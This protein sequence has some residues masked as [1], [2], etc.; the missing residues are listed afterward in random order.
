M[1]IVS[2]GDHSHEMSSCFLRK[3]KKKKSIT[4]LLS[5]VVMISILRIQIFKIQ[6]K[7][8]ALFSGQKICCLKCTLLSFF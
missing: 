7:C 4:N 3:N 5:A 8:E 2:Y 6:T 1:L